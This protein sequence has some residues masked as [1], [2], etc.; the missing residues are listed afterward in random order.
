MSQLDVMVI[1]K[2]LIMKCLY[3]CIMMEKKTIA[4][5]SFPVLLSKKYMVIF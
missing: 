2:L 5:P 4:N 1:I 3:S